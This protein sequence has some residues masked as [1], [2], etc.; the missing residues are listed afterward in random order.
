MRLECGLTRSLP[1]PLSTAF[2]STEEMSR[3]VEYAGRRDPRFV[4][5]HRGGSLDEARHR[6]L[7][8]WAADCAEHVLPLFTA[9]YP[10]D[11]R[12]RRAIEV[13]RAW[14]RGEAT[15]GEARAAVR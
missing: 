13:A 7:V 2:G 12:P 10:E 8:G 14:S 11:D 6:L 4:R 3:M 15:V 5:T 9:K 1:S